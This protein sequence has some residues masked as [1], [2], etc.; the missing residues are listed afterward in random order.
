MAPYVFPHVSAYDSDLTELVNL[1]IEL[2]KAYNDIVEELNTLESTVDDKLREQSEEVTRQLDALRLEV[3]ETIRLFT[4]EINGIIRDFEEELRLFREEIE[5]D[6]AALE[7]EIGDAIE[8][9]DTVCVTPQFIEVRADIDA[10]DDRVS[11]IEIEGIP[12]YYNPVAGE[13]TPIRRTIIDLYEVARHEPL[14][15]D[16]YDTLALTAAAYD[17]YNLTGLMYDLRGKDLLSA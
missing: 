3:G 4:E 17:A 11:Q 8:E 6:I 15:A 7:D 5:G 10:L 13:E 9:Y 12:D 2:S 14:T 16:E 1:Y